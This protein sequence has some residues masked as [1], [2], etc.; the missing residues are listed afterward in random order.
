MMVSKEAPRGRLSRVGA[1]LLMLI[2]LICPEA[3][4]E[5]QSDAPQGSLSVRAGQLATLLEPSASELQ[6][7]VVTAGSRHEQEFWVMNPSKEPVEVTQ[8][9]NSCDCFTLSL[10]SKF[11]DPGRKVSGIACVDFSHDPAFT[12][13]LCLEAKG[14]SSRSSI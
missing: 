13:T 1:L 3:C 11:V 5:R 4:S 6:F 2:A 12:G 14:S 8:V 9:P 10:P 7:G